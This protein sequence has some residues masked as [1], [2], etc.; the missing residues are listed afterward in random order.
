MDGADPGYG[1]R[2]GRGEEV[3]FVVGLEGAVGKG[4]APV[5][6]LGMVKG[7]R[8]KEADWTGNKPDVDIY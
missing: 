2:A 6:T 8:Y 3:V 5:C 7:E 1:R 4:K